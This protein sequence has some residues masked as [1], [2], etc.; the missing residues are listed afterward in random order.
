[1]RPKH[2]TS[3]ISALLLLSFLG[4]IG[5]AAV[6]E[7]SATRGASAEDC[8]KA[9]V[10]NIIS[11]QS[12]TQVWKN[13]LTFSQRSFESVRSSV[14]SW[15]A[16]ADVLVPVEGVPVPIGG[17]ASSLRQFYD[18]VKS[19]TTDYVNDRSV[20]FQWRSI[21]RNYVTDKQIAAYSDCIAQNQLAA[22]EAFIVAGPPVSVGT[23]YKCQLILRGINRIAAP[24]PKMSAMQLPSFVHETTPGTL[25]KQIEEWN[26]TTVYS[27]QTELEL[28]PSHQL[29]E[30]TFQFKGGWQVNPRSITVLRLS[31]VPRIELVVESGSVRDR[32]EYGVHVI[33]LAA[34]LVPAS[35]PKADLGSMRDWAS[36]G[37]LHTS[38]PK[39]D[40]A[41]SHFNETKNTLGCRL[42]EGESG[43]SLWVVPQWETT[44]LDAENLEEIKFGLTELAS[45][46]PSIPKQ[47]IVKAQSPCY[48]VPLS[49]N[50]KV[51]PQ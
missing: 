27:A 46:N 47:L 3:H 49:I 15:G 17:S 42:R 39:K 34:K 32:S 7:A 12:N 45:S 37:E 31:T 21:Y 25:S 11:E 28:D 36:I 9:L 23:S 4:A 24:S 29:A 44:G 30:V 35:I 2:F 18:S 20:A 50:V 14:D 38:D 48:T 41:G 19:L 5:L 8:E 40:P 10:P 13:L 6:H 51:L 22:L 1:M 43:L 16:T 26:K 33:R